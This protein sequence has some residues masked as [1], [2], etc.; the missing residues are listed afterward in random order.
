METDNKMQVFNNDEF[1]SVRTVIKDGEPWFV[2]VDVCRA[3]DI[4][5]T[6]TRRLDEDE[7]SAL[8]LTQT[9]SNGTE[10]GRDVTV[11]SESGLYSLVL[12]SR[13]PEAKAF[14]RWITHEVIPTIRKTGGYVANDDLF[15][16]TYFGD[17][18]ES[19]KS[20]F[21]ATLERVRRLN[22]EKKALNETVAVQSQQIAEMR[23]KVTYYDVIL[24]SPD[25]ITMSVIA[26]DYGKSAKWLN[27]KLNELGVQFKQGDIWLLYAEHADKGYTKTETYTYVDSSDIKHSRVHTKW[28]QKG[29]FFLYDLLKSNGVL[30]LCEQEEEEIGA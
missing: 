1:G 25:A 4:D 2:A 27:K 19:M 13:K 12:G 15:V 29:R 5:A 9:S 3:L 14:K 7:K 6:A 10:Q 28:T 21:R 20:A 8:R 11:I 23:P 26:K 17:A 18:D 24:N 22:E 30:P 16:E